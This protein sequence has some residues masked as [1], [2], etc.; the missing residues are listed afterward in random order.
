MDQHTQHTLEITTSG[1]TPQH[2]LSL[3]MGV[4]T[5]PS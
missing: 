3:G 4:E 5:S 1:H 2:C